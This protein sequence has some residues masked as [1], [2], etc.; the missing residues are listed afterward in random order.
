M[1]FSIFICIKLY[2]AADFRYAK[3]VLQQIHYLFQL[4]CHSSYI[5]LF[6]QFF[7]R[8]QEILIFFT[9]YT[10]SI[11]SNTFL[12]FLPFFLIHVPLFCF[13]GHFIHFL[14][15]RQDLLSP[16]CCFSCNIFLFY[17]PADMQI[18]F[19]LS[20][21][22]PGQISFFQHKLDE[23]CP[24]FRKFG[25]S[26]IFYLMDRY[27]FFLCFV[28]I[29]NRNVFPVFHFYRILFYF[30]FFPQFDQVTYLFQGQINPYLT[31]I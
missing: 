16:V 11:G 26:L 19:R 21:P 17:F 23:W 30:R 22:V 28:L 12:Q 20:Q 13:S 5:S 3:P 1:A 25:I 24:V 27:I 31:L 7:C 10:N 14:I 29:N 6:T 18:S 9:A 15:K 8:V 2:S 4:Y